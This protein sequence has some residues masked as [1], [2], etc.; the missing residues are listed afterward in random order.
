MSDAIRDSDYR[1]EVI[2]DFYRR[3]IESGEYGPGAQMPGCMKVAD[4]FRVR[5]GAVRVALKIL[6]D[7]GL[8]V[9]KSGNPLVA[10]TLPSPPP[11]A[12]AFRWPPPGA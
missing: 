11:E 6:R 4:L 5:A 1:I 10:K 2:A 12:S 8:I 7:E 9:L 3:L